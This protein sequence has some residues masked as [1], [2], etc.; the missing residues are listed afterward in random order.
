MLMCRDERGSVMRKEGSGEFRLTLR[1]Y[2]RS[3]R[4][5]STTLPRK[6]ARPPMEI[7]TEEEAGQASPLS[8]K[9][10]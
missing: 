4:Q 6:A 2:E 9:W 1:L 3:L 7:L 10:R 5:N 8:A